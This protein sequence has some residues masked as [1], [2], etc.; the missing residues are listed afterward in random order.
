MTE[1]ITYETIRKLHRAEKDEALNPLPENFFHAMNAWLKHKESQK[2]TTSLLEVESTK[3]LLEDLINRRERKIVTA[4][5]RSIRGDL[6][7]KNL[8]KEEQ[9]LFD[10]LVDILKTFH[11][12]LQEKVFGSN[13]EE[14]IK[15]PTEP[16]KK[17]QDINKE[18]I[19]KEGKLV[20]ILVDLQ[21]FIDGDLKSFGPMKSG[22]VVK[23]SSNVAKLLIARQVAEEIE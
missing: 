20:K 8:T 6:P 1:I 4:M 18:D 9:K 12:E 19:N 16:A 11:K 14:N 2:D 17:E 13:V 21:R 10:Q 15:K 7:P 5:L 23:L 22:D 3:K